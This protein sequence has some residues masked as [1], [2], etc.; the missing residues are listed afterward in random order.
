MRKPDEVA[1]YNALRLLTGGEAHYGIARSGRFADEVARD[2]GI[3]EKRAT[4]LLDKWSDRGWWD[5][6]VSARTGWFTPEAPQVM[7]PTG[8][9]VFPPQVQLM[10]QIHRL[11]R[12][13][14]ADDPGPTAAVTRRAR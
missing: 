9:A 14:T 4:F 2:L 1:L 8:A 12:P 13:A 6:G 10:P 5:Y 3:P 11:P 7:T